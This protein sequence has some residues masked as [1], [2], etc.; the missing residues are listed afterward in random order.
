MGNTAPT[1]RYEYVSKKVIIGQA[2]PNF[3]TAHPESDNFAL[4]T[5]LPDE[6]VMT[7]EV[8]KGERCVLMELPEAQQEKSQRIFKIIK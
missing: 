1:I 6:E 7:V 4:A 2:L 8:Q 5:N 3:L